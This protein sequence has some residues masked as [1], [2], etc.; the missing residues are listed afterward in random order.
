MLRSPMNKS[1]G[2]IQRCL[3]ESAREARLFKSARTMQVRARAQRQLLAQQS[4]LASLSIVE[5]SSK[6]VANV[7][8]RARH[9]HISTF[10]Q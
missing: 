2:K 4:S 8:A 5:F 6:L 1:V 7:N 10:A 9:Y 3:S